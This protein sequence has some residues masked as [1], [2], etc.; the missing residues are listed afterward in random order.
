MKVKVKTD[1]D[2][3]AMLEHERA[4]IEFT[5]DGDSPNCPRSWTFGLWFDGKYIC[6]TA[7]EASLAKTVEEA[8][9]SISAIINELTTIRDYLIAY[10]AFGKEPEVSA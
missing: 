3:F 4:L 8:T 2:D 1:G 10:G 9:D 5:K 7:D 6:G